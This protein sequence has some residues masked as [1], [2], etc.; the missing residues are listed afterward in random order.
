MTIQDQIEQDLKESE[1]KQRPTNGRPRKYPQPQDLQKAIDRYFDLEKFPTVTG[2]YRHLGLSRAG[3]WSYKQRPDFSNILNMGI[4]R[5][6]E[7]YE[8]RLVYGDGKNT[9]GLIMGLRRIWA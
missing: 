8:R 7:I 5:I 3:A 1:A 6:A 2:L 4:Q 9:A